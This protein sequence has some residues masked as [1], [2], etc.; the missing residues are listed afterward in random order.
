VPLHGSI[1]RRSVVVQHFLYMRAFLSYLQYNAEEQKEVTFR[2][3]YYVNKAAF[4]FIHA[5]ISLH[6]VYYG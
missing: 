2:S 5:R 1:E 3:S 4:R 6:Y